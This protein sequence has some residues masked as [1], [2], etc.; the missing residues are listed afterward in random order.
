MPRPGPGGKILQKI[1]DDVQ[2]YRSR[3]KETGLILIINKEEGPD[4][5]KP[6]ATRMVIRYSVPN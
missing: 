1:S 4:E 6:P 5:Q 2:G 3:A